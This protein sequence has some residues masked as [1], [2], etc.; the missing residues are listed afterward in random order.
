MDYDE[1]SYCMY[2][3]GEI[4]GCSHDCTCCQIK[5]NYDKGEYRDRHRSLDL[6]RENE[7]L[8]EKLRRY[9]NNIID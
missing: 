6:E 3:C 8:K 7:M 9:E 5:M 4:Y 1:S 2:Y